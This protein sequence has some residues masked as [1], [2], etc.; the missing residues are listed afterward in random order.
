MN[1]LR[2]DRYLEGDE[3]NSGWLDTQI[4]PDQGGTRLGSSLLLLA[5]GVALR[6]S[7]RGPNAMASTSFETVPGCC[8]AAPACVTGLFCGSFCEEWMEVARPR[9]VSRACRVASYPLTPF[10]VADRVQ[11]VAKPFRGAP[12]LW[13]RRGPR[14]SG[15]LA[16]RG[17]GRGCRTRQLPPGWTDAVLRLSES[18]GGDMHGINGP[19][20]PS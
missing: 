9:D 5:C 10:G 13:R 6:V 14:D 4:T 20:G 7:G 12:P 11:A 1:L 16:S 18:K 3:A 19:S 15:G 8:E 17:P 2:L